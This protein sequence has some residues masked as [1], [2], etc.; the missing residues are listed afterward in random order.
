MLLNHLWLEPTNT[1]G[2]VT[3]SRKQQQT[4]KGFE[5]FSTV[6]FGIEQLVECVVF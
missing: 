4:L 5:V 2:K 3:C 1:E 6:M